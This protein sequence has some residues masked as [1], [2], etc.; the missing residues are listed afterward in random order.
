MKCENCNKLSDEIKLLHNELEL[1]YM[2]KNALEKLVDFWELEARR[3]R[4][5]LSSRGL[6]PQGKEV[7]KEKEE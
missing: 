3:L 7:V 1:A 6:C 2:D 5:E 4:D